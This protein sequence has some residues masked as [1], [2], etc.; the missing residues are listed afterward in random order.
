MSTAS[1]AVSLP[2]LSAVVLVAA[3]LAVPVQSVAQEHRGGLNVGVGV[4]LGSVK[5]GVNATVGGSKG[6]ADAKVGASVGGAKGINAKASA[7]VGGSRGLVDAGVT[8]SVGGSGGLGAKVGATVGG[9]GLLNANVGLGLGSTG[10]RPGT[11]GGGVM[12]STER[13]TLRQFSQ[14]SRNERMQLLK[15]CGGIDNGGYDAA[16]VKLCRLLEMASR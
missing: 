4:S 1:N 5:A 8:A 13:R 9:G 7:N 14:L 12:T 10:V 3:I 11:S 6:L 16:L 2:R 15:R